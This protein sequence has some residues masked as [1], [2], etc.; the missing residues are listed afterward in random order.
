MFIPEETSHCQKCFHIDVSD[1]QT[2]FF[3][4]AFLSQSHKAVYSAVSTQM[5]D[6]VSDCV[7]FILFALMLMSD[8][9]NETFAEQVPLRM[10]MLTDSFQV[11]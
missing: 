9:E 4:H 5:D 11:L 10:G 8:V 3:F 7:L 2:H 1:S 6:V